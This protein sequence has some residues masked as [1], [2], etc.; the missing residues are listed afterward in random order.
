MF[1]V[2]PLKHSNKKLV[3]VGILKI[4]YRFQNKHCDNG[5]LELTV[6]RPLPVV[7]PLCLT[8]Q[9]H[10]QLT[11]A[12][13]TVQELDLLLIN[14]QSK[15]FK[16]RIDKITKDDSLVSVH[17]VILQSPERSK[18]HG[19]SHLHVVLNPNDS[20]FIKIVVFG[21]VKGI[22]MFSFLRFMEVKPQ[23]SPSILEYNSFQI[24]VVN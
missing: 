20:V 12:H 8:F 9:D 21:K 18:S 24:Q 3:D 17:K 5:R 14:N 22:S 13:H 10:N 2:N 19:K 11:I 6:T 1:S 7:K 15:L 16:V 23:E 4:N